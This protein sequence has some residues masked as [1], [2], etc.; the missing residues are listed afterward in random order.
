MSVVKSTY[1]FVFY[2]LA[3]VLMVTTLLIIIQPSGQYYRV[4]TESA[5]EITLGIL[6][7]GLLCLLLQWHRLMFVSFACAGILSLFLK[8]STNPAPVYATPIL[9]E[10]IEVIHLNISSYEGSVYEDLTDLLLR[11][12]ADLISIQ[13]VDPEWDMVLRD[14]LSDTYPYFSSVA[15]VGINGLAIF[16]KLRLT[17]LDTFYHNNIPNLTGLIEAKKEGDKPIR[18]I[19]T[20]T[21]PAFGTDK[22][23][24]ELRDHF[25]AIIDKVKDTA[26]ARLALGTYNTVAWSSEMKF[27]T[28]ELGLQNSRRTINPFS[29]DT[30]EHIF[31]SRDIECVDFDGIYDNSE[32]RIGLKIKLHHKKQLPDHYHVQKP[33]Q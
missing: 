4:F 19:S 7:F 21:N 18:F 17:N 33:S 28:G 1:K 5:V 10:D 23:Y 32:E 25:E 15:S 8:S 3:L 22:F 26:G 29:E 2:P 27:F 30:Y 11:T 13:E 12:D 14:E 16:S 9:E 20:Y 31:H 24:Q 6:G